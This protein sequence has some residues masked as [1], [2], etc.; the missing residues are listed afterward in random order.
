MT[1][2][3]FLV[4]L[5]LGIIPLLLVLKFFK[6]RFLFIV[7]PYIKGAL[8]GFIL[9]C[10]I[11]SVLYFETRFGIF[12]FLDGDEGF[13]SMLLITSS[14][15]GFITAGLLAALVTKTLWKDRTPKS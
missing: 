13:R 5:F 1:I 2:W 9:W 7:N 14:S 12:G 6:G 3:G 11:I 10:V 8:L 4:G 15:H